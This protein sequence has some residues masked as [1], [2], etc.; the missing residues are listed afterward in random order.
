MNK[1]YNL[2]AK[3]PNYIRHFG[4]INGLRVLYKKEGLRQLPQQSERIKQYSPLRFDSPIYL[5]DC[6]GDHAIF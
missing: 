3:S 2:L 6:I 1:I 4:V 5:R